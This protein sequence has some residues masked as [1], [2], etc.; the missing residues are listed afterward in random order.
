MEGW[1]GPGADLRIS[2][3]RKF[4]KAYIIVRTSLSAC[5]MGFCSLLSAF[6]DGDLLC[7]VRSQKFQQTFS[8]IWKPARDD[9]EAANKDDEIPRTFFANHQSGAQ[10]ISFFQQ[11][12]MFG[13]WI[14]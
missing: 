11:T 10:R 5:E 3:K 7:S 6:E 12:T 14:F 4:Q 9:F 13:I 1:V 8:T 2:K